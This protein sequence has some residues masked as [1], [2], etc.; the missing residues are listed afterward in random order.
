MKWKNLQMPKPL[1]SDAGNNDSY[2][3][4]VLEPLERGFGSTLG[5]ALRRVLLSSLQGAAITAVR[6][7]GVLHEFSTLPGVI[8][9]VTEIVELRQRLAEAFPTKK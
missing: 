4:F 5:N 8:E 3:K 9:D 6:I 2:G 7:D 1:I